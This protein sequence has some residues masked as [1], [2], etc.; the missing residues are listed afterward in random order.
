M[1]L[2][3]PHIWWLRFRLLAVAFLVIVAILSLSY[4]RAEGCPAATNSIV[5]QTCVATA[6]CEQPA[7]PRSATL[8][9]CGSLL[10]GL[11]V[12]QRLS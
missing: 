9:L 8:A 12:N 4:D 10:I 2:D 11:G 3:T 1:K 6:T 5:A 7:V